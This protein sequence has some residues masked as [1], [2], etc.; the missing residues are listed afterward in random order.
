MVQAVALTLA[1]AAAVLEPPMAEQQLRQI[2][3][4]LGWQPDAWRRTGRPGHPAPMYHA[5]RLMRLHAALAPF[6]N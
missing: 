3:T 5:E 2:V 6:T 1:E 4:A